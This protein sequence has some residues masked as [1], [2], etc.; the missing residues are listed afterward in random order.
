MV[1]SLKMLVCACVLLP[2]CCACFQKSTVPPSNLCMCVREEF[3]IRIEPLKARHD[4]TKLDLTTPLL[5]FWR[6][7]ID[8]SIQSMSL[9][10]YMTWV[11]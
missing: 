5:S 7:D 2:N 4:V 8:L 6:I 11:R 3:P 10:L 1:L 9:T